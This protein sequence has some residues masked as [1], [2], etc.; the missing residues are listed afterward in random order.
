MYILRREII[1]HSLCV[2]LENA[3]SNEGNGGMFN[4]LGC[5]V[6]IIPEDIVEQDENFN[7]QDIRVKLTPGKHIMLT[8]PPDGT[9]GAV[10]Y[11]RWGKKTCRR[12]AKLVYEGYAGGGWFNQKGKWSQLSLPTKRS[13]VFKYCCSHLAVLPIWS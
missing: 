4:N 9:G 6:L 8:F 5:N 2:D 3:D 13:S 12:G 10:T 7:A 1:F 11:T